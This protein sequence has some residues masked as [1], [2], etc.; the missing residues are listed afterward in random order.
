MSAEE[1]VAFKRDNQGG[2]VEEVAPRP[3]LDRWVV[4]QK[5]HLGMDKRMHSVYSENG[6]ESRQGGV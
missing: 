1:E 5:A 2:S 6:K 4:S 3:G